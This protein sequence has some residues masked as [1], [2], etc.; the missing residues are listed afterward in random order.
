MGGTAAWLPAPGTGPSPSTAVDAAGAAPGAGGAPGGASLG[1]GA[2]AGAGVGTAAAG[3]V[4]AVGGG[5]GACASKKTGAW[6][7]ASLASALI[8]SDHA[9][10]QS[11]LSPNTAPIRRA[12]GLAPSWVRV[13]GADAGRDEEGRSGSSGQRMAALYQILHA[14]R[15]VVALGMCAASSASR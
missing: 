14:G 8:R 7:W 12:P 9:P 6:A 2:G 5:A 10:P 15:V 1:A 3:L 13:R 4:T 11:T